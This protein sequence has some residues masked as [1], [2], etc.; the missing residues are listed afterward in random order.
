MRPLLEAN[1]LFHQVHQRFKHEC[2]QDGYQQRY[3]NQF[4]YITD[5]QNHSCSDDH[6]RHRSGVQGGVEPALVFLFQLFFRQVAVRGFL[7]HELFRPR[8]N[9]A[10]R[11]HMTR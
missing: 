11:G 2:Q 8:R 10:I 5:G 1:G 6:L 9:N 4:G 7:R 3:Q